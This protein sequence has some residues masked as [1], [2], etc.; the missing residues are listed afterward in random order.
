D[1]V[2]V[3]SRNKHTGYESS[4]WLVVDRPGIY[5]RIIDHGNPSGRARAEII[6]E[7]SELSFPE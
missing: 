6:S 2:V 1:C 5:A 7:L 4:W 3:H